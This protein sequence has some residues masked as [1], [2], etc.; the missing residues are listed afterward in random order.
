MVA[1][2]DP[3][4]TRRSS[5]GRALESSNAKAADAQPLDLLRNTSDVLV[6]CAHELLK[7]GE[8]VVTAFVFVPG[9]LHS[10]AWTWVP[11]Q[12]L[13]RGNILFP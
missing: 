1:V 12:Q 11:L 5:R 10:L 8:I 7:A 2:V 6:H 9:M 4:P 13:L 3:L